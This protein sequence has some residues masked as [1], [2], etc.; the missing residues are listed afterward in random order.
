VDQEPVPDLSRIYDAYRAKVVAYAAKLL[1]RGDADHV[2]RDVFVKVG[3]F[4][5]TL[6]EPSRTPEETAA[7]SVGGHQKSQFSD[8]GR[9][10]A[11]VG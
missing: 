2:A 8:Q 9:L 6:A 10:M 1:G 7:T 5:A 3:R 11:G 4:L